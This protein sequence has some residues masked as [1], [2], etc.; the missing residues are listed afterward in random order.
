MN[1]QQLD[2]Y[3]QIES[4]VEGVNSRKYK[5]TTR[6]I[7]KR[8]VL[9]FAKIIIENNIPIS[10][11]R[12]I[13]TLHLKAYGEIEVWKKGRRISVVIAELQGVIHYYNTLNLSVARY[14]RQHLLDLRILKNYL[15]G[16]NDK[17]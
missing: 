17:I 12:N 15:E 5:K 6:K 2:R 16:R 8:Y 3:L 14:R 13:K 1:E 9:K 10:S 11:I 4:E 7:Y